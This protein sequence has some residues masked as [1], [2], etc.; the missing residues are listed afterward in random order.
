MRLRSRADFSRT[1][2]VG[3]RVR[4]GLI[5]VVAARPEH[6]T[7]PRLGLSVGRRWHR[8]AV[9]RNRLK[10]LLREAFRLRQHD[11]PALDLVLIPRA[12]AS[13]FDLGA[14]GDELVTLA[15]RAERRIGR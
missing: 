3:V 7:G 11:L 14:L 15:T 1:Y 12:P 4:G 9:V 5:L 13:A 10:R 6:P 2:R 8:S